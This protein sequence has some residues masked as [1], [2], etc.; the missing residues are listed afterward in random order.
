MATAI[1]DDVSAW[2]SVPPRDVI[3][4]IVRR[5][6][7]MR[8]GQVFHTDRLA[9]I[10]PETAAFNAAASG[11]LAIPISRRPRDYILLFRREQART[12]SWGGDPTK[13]VDYGPNGP[14]LTPRASFDAWLEEVKGRSL[15][16]SDAEVQG[17]ET[18]RASLVE[19]VL[20]LSEATVDERRR[21]IERQNLLIGEL[22]HRVRN[23]LALIRSI[24]RQSRGSEQSLAEYMHQIEGRI[25]ALARAHDQLTEQ[26][27]A[28]AGLR[29]L[30][31]TEAKAYLDA[32]SER[33][34]VDGPAVA[35]SPL[36]YSTLALV[37]HEL[38]TNSA[39]HGALSDSGA[40]SVAWTFDPVSGLVITWTESGGPTVSQPTRRGFGA[41]VIE[42]A[43][44]HDLGGTAAVTYPPSG[45]EAVLTIPPQY[46]ELQGDADLA[47]AAQHRSARPARAATGGVPERVLLVEDS[48][49]IAMDTEDALLGFGVNEVRLASSVSLAL[50]ELDTHRPDFAVLDLN[51]GNETSIPVARRLVEIGVPFLF[52]TGYGEKAMLDPELERVPIIVK[53][54]NASDLLR[55]MG[56]GP[57]AR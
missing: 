29:Q 39:K 11:V 44:P 25:E 6:N 57:V 23:I 53:P 16:F 21:A 8:P 20:Q 4:D 5:L 40:V 28:A 22:N 45:V 46:V 18:L 37:V 38:V 1:D 12:V 34:T 32:K 51:L 10:I 24:M 43:M 26:R 33:L 35:L 50:E 48:L 52:A 14:R 9:D 15:A 55:G 2:G 56:L 41:T 49:L 47:V 54:Y 36:A 3:P 42:R 19:V 7:A 31:E 27:F 30:I 13:P 17:A